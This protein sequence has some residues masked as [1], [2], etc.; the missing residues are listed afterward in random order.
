[1]RAFPVLGH[2]LA[3]GDLGF[4]QM[5]CSPICIVVIRRI[6]RRTDDHQPLVGFEIIPRQLGVAI[7][8]RQ[9]DN[10]VFD[11]QIVRRIIR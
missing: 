11:L 4:G 10:R 6:Q 3:F 9:L 7:K 1:M 8:V 2:S 5:L